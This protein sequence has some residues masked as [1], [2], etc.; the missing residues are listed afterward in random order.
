MFLR[1]LQLPCKMTNPKSSVVRVKNSATHMFIDVGVCCDETR[2]QQP[3]ASRMN[4]NRVA[5]K[6]CVTRSDLLTNL[7]ARGDESDQIRNAI[8]FSQRFKSS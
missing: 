2:G 6:A 3:V 8:V 7:F 1:V 5:N 4:G